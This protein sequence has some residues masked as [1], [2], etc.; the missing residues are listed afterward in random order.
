[1]RPAASGNPLPGI[2]RVD[3]NKSQPSGQHSQITFRVTPD[4]LEAA[5]WPGIR[6]GHIPYPAHSSSRTRLTETQL[7]FLPKRIR[8]DHTC[9]RTCPG[10]YLAAS[11]PAHALLFGQISV[12]HLSARAQTPPASGR[13]A[14]PGNSR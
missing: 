11:A 1:M 2:A 6:A 14:T 4:A 12:G 8:R 3:T 5:L 13:R 7:T 10:T 9:L